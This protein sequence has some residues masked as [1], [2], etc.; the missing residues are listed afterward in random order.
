MGDGHGIFNMRTNL[1]QGV[2]STHEGRSGTKSAHTHTHGVAQLVEYRLEIQRP[3]VR[4]P[5]GAQEKFV[6]VFPS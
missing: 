5:S 3:E 1:H 6:R 2:C 4:T